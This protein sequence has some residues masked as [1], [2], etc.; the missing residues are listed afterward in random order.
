MS[1]KPQSGKPR[2]KAFVTGGLGNVGAWVLRELTQLGF[3]LDCFDISSANNEKKA[4]ELGKS[5]PFN[6]IWGDLTKPQSV[7][8]ALELSRPDVLVHVAAIIPP[9]SCRNPS[10]AHKVN[11]RGTELLLRQAELQ[12]I[13]R[14]VF[15]S[16]Y[17]VYGPCNPNRSPP[18][19][20][21]DTPTNP[22]DDYARQ[23][24][25]A[26]GIVRSS[27]LD[28][29]IVRLCAVFPLDTA[30]AP[31]DLMRFN[32]LLPF[33]RLE[34]GIDVRDAALAIA[35]AAVVP[36]AANRTFVVG[37]P[38]GW[39]QTGGEISGAVMRAA[40]IAP[41]PRA[42]FRLPDPY[43]DDSWYFEN[44]VDTS[45]SQ[46]VL[47]YQRFDFEDYLLERR[48]RMGIV[49]YILPLFAGAARKALLK[50][51]KYLSRPQQPDPR[52]F[53]EVEHIEFSTS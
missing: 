29:V 5:A 2:K 31:S 24:V 11:V 49:K 47:D 53:A 21:A 26:E 20:T 15:V 33:D 37:G 8:S 25:E 52:P 18:P 19:W 1:K 6:M 51:S 40:G 4:V 10:L 35:K 14:F 32:F 41:F 7:Q 3:E 48:R 17:S 9:L 36:D 23:K 22:K 46:A 43:I 45:E 16:S 42:A 50:H 34:Q 13:D 30:G 44:F 39:Q 12:G 27:K 28:H 38:K